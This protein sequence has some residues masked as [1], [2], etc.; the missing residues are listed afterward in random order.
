M[1]MRANEGKGAPWRLP[2]VPS[3]PGFLLDEDGEGIHAI[4]A[5]ALLFDSETEETDV[6]G[7]FADSTATLQRFPAIDVVFSEGAALRLR[8]IRAGFGA[9]RF[10]RAG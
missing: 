4:E 3:R 1:I 5:V 9:R 6:L 7:R 8:A 10:A 2:L